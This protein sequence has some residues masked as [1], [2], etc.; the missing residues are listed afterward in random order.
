MEEFIPIIISI[1]VLIFILFLLINKKKSSKKPVVQNRHTIYET[2]STNIGM[3][4]PTSKLHVQGTIIP[5]KLEF[6]YGTVFNK[7]EVCSDKKLRMKGYTLDN[8][9]DKNAVLFKNSDEPLKGISNKITVIQVRGEKFGVL[10]DHNG[11]V[12]EKFDC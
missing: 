3:I 1:S 10:L 2:S 11:V 12:Q 9:L 7:E 8:N 5:M 4:N 6:S